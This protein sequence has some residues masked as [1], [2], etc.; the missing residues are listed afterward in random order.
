MKDTLE[1]YEENPD[2]YIIP[3]DSDEKLITKLS[4]KSV[5]TQPLLHCH[6][7]IMQWSHYNN[8]CPMDFG[9]NCN[10]D[11]CKCTCSF[12]WPVSKTAE[13][14]AVINVEKGVPVGD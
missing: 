12:V 14:M 9:G 8:T 7:I 6:C 5:V 2:V 4:M 1:K 10:C 3:L 11:N 13:F